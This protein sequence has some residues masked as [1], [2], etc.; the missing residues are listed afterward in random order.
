[1]TLSEAKDHLERTIRCNISPAHM[2]IPFDGGVL[3]LPG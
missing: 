2:H 1:M 3:N